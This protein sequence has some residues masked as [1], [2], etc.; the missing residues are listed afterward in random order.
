MSLTTGFLVLF[1][2]IVIPGFL[3]LRSYYYGEFSKQFNPKDNITKQ[4]LFGIIPGSI[5]QMVCFLVGKKIGWITIDSMHVLSFFETVNNQEF[6]QNPDAQNMIANP[7]YL[8][9]YLL[10]VYAISFVGGASI[11]RLIRA[12][13]LDKSWKILRFKNQWYYIFSGEIFDFKKFKSAANILG[14]VAEDGKNKVI[15]LSKVDVLISNGG[16]HEFYSG[17]VVDYDLLPNDPSKLDNLYLMDTYRHTRMEIKNHNSELVHPYKSEKKAI[18]GEIFVLNM[19]NLVNI[20]VSYLLSKKTVKEQSRGRK[21]V[22]RSLNAILVIVLLSSIYPIFFKVDTI[23]NSWYVSFH[24]NAWWL[25]KTLLLG[26]IMGIVSIPLREKNK[27]TGNYEITKRDSL[28]NVVV[29]A[30]FTVAFFLVYYF[31]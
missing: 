23:E 26:S 7:V 10:I 17:Y 14:K 18:P 16:E 31:L 19:C 24:N 2:T 20:N 27:E 6:S 11:S 21:I 1:F 12:S 25:D 5:I 3:F 8:G 30:G 13:N 15:E 28:I 22:H 4:L 29:F 9:Y